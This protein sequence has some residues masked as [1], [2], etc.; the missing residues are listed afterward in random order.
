[1]TCFLL[2]LDIDMWQWHISLTQDWSTHKAAARGW[3]QEETRFEFFPVKICQ[4]EANEHIQAGWQLKWAQT[5][6]YHTIR[7]IATN[8]GLA[9]GSCIWRWQAAL[10]I[11]GFRLILKFQYPN[12]KNKWSCSQ[13]PWGFNSDAINWSS[14]H[15]GSK[16]PQVLTKHT[17]GK[18]QTKKISL[19]Y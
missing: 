11:I 3:V 16:V 8:N 6:V 19:T 15:L 18:F 7:N 17:K 13:W 5:T 12:W 9:L 1:M 2:A 4:A 10:I 14:S